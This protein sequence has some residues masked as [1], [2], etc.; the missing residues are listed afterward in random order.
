M[1]NTDME[2]VQADLFQQVYLPAYIEKCAELGLNAQSPE[3]LQG[4]LEIS[5]SVDMLQQ[6]QQHGNIKEAN[7]TLKRTL[8]IDKQEEQ[9]KQAQQLRE[10]AQRFQQNPEAKAAVAKL[11]GI[12]AE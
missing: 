11:L 7:A 2:K 3:D 12:G 5:A 6:Q 9:E 10:T 1:D 8:G 4:L